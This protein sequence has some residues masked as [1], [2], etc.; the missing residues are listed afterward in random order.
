[1]SPSV[2]GEAHPPQTE[3]SCAGHAGIWAKQ[4]PACGGGVVPLNH[5]VFQTPGLLD[6]GKLYHGFR[7]FCQRFSMLRRFIQWQGS[8]IRVLCAAFAV[9]GAV[10][11]QV[12]AGIA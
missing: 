12:G 2:T 9:V 5:G 8:L 6:L 3:L 7:L 10:V 1:M 11:A 4:Y